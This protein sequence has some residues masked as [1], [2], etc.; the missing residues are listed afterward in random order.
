M[1][2]MAG[3]MLAAARELSRRGLSMLYDIHFL[4]FIVIHFGGPAP[5][6]TSLKARLHFII[7]IAEAKREFQ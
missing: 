5:I 2:M 7:Y 6:M 1:T 4:I 3:G